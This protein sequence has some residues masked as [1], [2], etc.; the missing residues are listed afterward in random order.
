[1]GFMFADGG[2]PE[3]DNLHVEVGAELAEAGVRHPLA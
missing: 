2:V 3:F 1:M